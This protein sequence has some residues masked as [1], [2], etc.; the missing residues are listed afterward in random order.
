M[1]TIN[2][3]ETSWKVIADYIDQ[4]TIR[5]AYMSSTA[6]YNHGARRVWHDLLELGF[7]CGLHRVERLMQA[8]ALRARP[9][10]RGLPPD[11][12]QRS[13]IADNVLDRQ[14]V[15]QAPNQKWMADFTYI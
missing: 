4:P 5:R 9:R 8:Q 12:G 13:T 6:R 7:R 10:R 1:V 14:F 11:R 3:S 15:A 2:A